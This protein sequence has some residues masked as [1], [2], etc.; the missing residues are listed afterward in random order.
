MFGTG[1][2]FFFPKMKLTLKGERFSDISDIQHDVTKLLKGV[3]FQDC[4]RAVEDLYKR[5]QNC[6][7]L[8]GEYVESW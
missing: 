6:V 7:D 2:V 4:Q 5:S 3:S 1:R 8:G